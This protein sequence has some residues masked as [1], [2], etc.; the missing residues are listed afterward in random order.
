MGAEG[1]VGAAAIESRN[2]TDRLGRLVISL[3]FSRS[4]M[5]HHALKVMRAYGNVGVVDEKK[6]VAGLLCKLRQRADFAI[7]AEARGTLDETNSAIR[8]FAL[9]LLHG[10]NGWVVRRRNA[11]EEFEFAE[12]VLVAMGA[13]GI[14][15]AGIEALERFENR[16]AGSE[17][18]ER[19]A[20]R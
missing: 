1:A 12:I 18:S 16:Y 7:R 8:E 4:E 20:P 15:H 5:G 3:G 17:G 9:Q 19:C 6:F 11:K 2:E 13:K 14:E 10:G